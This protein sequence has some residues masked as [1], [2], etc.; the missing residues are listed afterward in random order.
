MTERQ[1]VTT[2]IIDAIEPID[3]ADRIEVAKVGGWRVVVGKD[4]FKAGDEVLY[5]EVDSALP[6]DSDHFSFL[7]PRGTKNIDGKDYHVLKT[8][9]LRGVY[10][11]GLVLPIEQFEE[12]FL[13]SDHLQMELVDVLGVIKY[14]PPVPSS[15][16]GDIAGAFFSGI[17][18][19]DAER[20]QNIS[21]EDYQRM[22][23]LYDWTATLK[24]DGTSA[25]FVND[26]GEI[27]AASRNWELRRSEG[28]AHW[29]IVD[30][31]NLSEVIPP[32]WVVQGEIYG[33]GIQGNP[34]KVKDLTFSVF[35]VTNQYGLDAVDWPRELIDLGVPVLDLEFPATIEEAV[36]QVNG[37][38]YNDILSE[39]VVWHEAY[40]RVPYGLD[41]PC[42]KVIN[43]KYLIKHGG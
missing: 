2:R 26:G 25:T 13:G 1:L 5:F 42:F 33:P 11:Q 23:D 10:S 16:S 4:E 15:V 3:N 30:K 31:Y 12:D 21:P 34:M 37:L 24:I 32:G 9:R 22:V 20:V 29:Q 41:R 36:E 39:G 28:N 14:E 8:I 19:T 38:R 40:G 18:K 27:R 17:Q 43:N 35:R 6:L 7:A